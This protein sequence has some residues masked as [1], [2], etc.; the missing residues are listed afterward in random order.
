MDKNNII[1]PIKKPE[2]ISPKG[3]LESGIGPKVYKI[4]VAKETAPISNTTTSV[5]KVKIVPNT[6]AIST[7]VIITPSTVPSFK[8]SLPITLVFL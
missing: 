6:M 8:L 3:I 4:P 1:N 7:R 2:K 5:F